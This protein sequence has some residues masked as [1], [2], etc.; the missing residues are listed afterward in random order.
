MV[1]GV[2]FDLGG[3]LFSYRGSRGGGRMVDEVARRL[4]IDREREELREAW[5]SAQDRTA[6]EYAQRPYFL[7]RD[8][9]RDGLRAFAESMGARPSED[10]LAWFETTQRNATVEN[11][12][13]REDCLPTLRMLKGHGLYLSIASNI[14][15]D[16]LDPL[17]ARHQLDS[18]LDHWTSSEAARACKPNPDFFRY[19]L[20]RSGL[21]AD[22]VLF[23]GDSLHHDIVGANEVGMRTVQIVEEGTVTPLTAGLTATAEPDHRIGELSELVDIVGAVR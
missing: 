11:L 13:I 19:V 9:F 8:L 15:D 1:R 21:A 16:F 10:L 5:R 7:H 20:E 2:F 6:R 12:P 4:G 17:V 18:V 23:V 22:E 14:D 3:T